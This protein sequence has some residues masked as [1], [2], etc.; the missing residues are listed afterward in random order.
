MK[1]HAVRLLSA[2]CLFLLI[3]GLVPGKQES[4][5]D[6]TSSDMRIDAAKRAQLVAA[7]GQLPLRF[8]A[9]RGQVSAPVKFLSRNG[10]HT[11]FLTA[12]EAVLELRN[13]DF[14]LRNEKHLESVAT[15]LFDES[16]TGNPK[17]AIVRMRL[18]GAN[19]QANVS[20]LDEL[21]GKS[22]Y[23]IGNDPRRW[24]TNVANF[25]RV[26]YDEV[27]PG[28]DLVWHGDQRQ[29][30][31]DFVLAPGANPQQ[32]RLSFSGAQKL[33]INE[34]GDLALQ[35][36]VG[37]VKLLKPA[38][39]Q[40]LS[41]QRQP[42][43]CEFIIN[44]K[45]QI[46][47]RLG[48]YDRNREL[49]IDPVLLYSTYLGGGGFDWCQG[50]AVDKDANAYVVGYTNSLNF[51]GSSPIQSSLNGAANDAF[52]VKLN[53]SGTE[54]MYKSWIGGDADDSAI[55][56]A[57]DKDGGA[58][59]GGN[60]SSNNFP[61]T[62][63]VL[64]PTKGV[65]RD[66]FLVRLNATG[67]A[68][69]Y[70]GYLGGNG[71]DQLNG[72][73]IDVAGNA[74][75]AGHTT[76]TNLPATGIQTSR[77]GSPIFKSTNR[78][79]NWSPSGNGLPVG[80]VGRITV[81]PSNSMTL[82]AATAIGVFKSTDGGV[83]WAA[84]GQANPDSTPSRA[85]AV[86][87]DPSNSSTVYVTTSL[88]GFYKSTDGGQ[89]YQGKNNGINFVTSLF[90]HELVI[91]P[92]MTSTLYL[93][94]SSGAYKSIN[95]GE[96]WT[97][98]NSGFTGQ[99]RGVRGM[100]IDPSNRMILYAATDRGV[101]KTTDGGANWVLAGNGLGQASSEIGM[102]AID[103]LS[104][105]TVYA[106][107]AGIYG[108]LFKTTDGGTTWR[109]SNIGLGSNGF[110]SVS[111]LAIDPST[112]ALVYAVTSSGLYKTIDGGLNWSE[113]NN[114]LAAIAT[115][116]AVDRTNSANVYVGV[117]VGTDGFAAKV[118]ATGS[119]F[120]WLTYLGGSLNDELRG[121]A[122]DK[123]GSAY[124][125]GIAVSNDFPTVSPFQ[126]AIGGA[127]DAIVAKVNPAGTALVYSTFFG[128]SDSDSA[129]AI[130]VNDAGQ[131][132]VTGST[133]SANFPTKNPLQPAYG[134][135]NVPDAF[136]A[137][138]NFA[139]SALEYST[140]LGGSVNDSGVAIAIDGLGNAYITGNTRSTNFPLMNP[141][142]SQLRFMDVYVAKL[143]PAGS[144]LVY[145]TLLGGDSDELVGSLAV[146]SRGNVYVVGVTASFNFPIVNPLQANMLISPDGFIAKLTDEADLAITKTVSR[147][148]VMVANNFSFVL[149]ATN[150]G[151][152]PATGVVV[153][154]QLPAGINFV[155]ATASQG[156]CS[157][158]AGMVTCNLGNLAVRASATIMLTVSAAAAGSITNT[159]SVKANEPDGISANN[160]ASAS[161]TVSNQPS[162]YGRVHLVNGA[163]LAGVTMTMTGALS[164]TQQTNVQGNFQFA[165]LL[166]SGN[167][168]V[169]PVSSAYSFE[170][171]VRDFNLVTSDQSGDFVA[172][173]CTYSLSATGQRFE[174][175]GGNDSFNLTAPPRCPWAITT[176]ASWIK[177]TSALS[178]AGNGSIS[179]SVEPTAVPRSGRISVGGQTFNVLQ[180]ISSCVQSKRYFYPLMPR[181]VTPGDLNGDGFS[182][183]LI[184]PFL[185]SGTSSSPIYPIGILFGEASGQLMPGAPIL[186]K[187]QPV[188]IAAGD[189]NGD[190]KMDVA[191]LPF[192]IQGEAEVFLNNG[193]SGFAAV[194]NVP[195]IP[196]NWTNFIGNL[197]TADLNKD[198]K[199]DLIG[200][201]GPV[202]TVAFSNSSGGNISFSASSVVNLGGESFLSLADLNADGASDLLTLNNASN[203]NLVVYLNNGAG[204][205]AQSV[206]T[207][208]ASRVISSD[209]AD[210]NGDGKVDLATLA[211]AASPVG[212]LMVGIQPGDG[213]GRFGAPVNSESFLLGS[214]VGGSR[215]AVSDVNGD[216]KPDVIAVG[217]TR[218]VVLQGNGAG[219]VNPAVEFAK[220][221]EAVSSVALANFEA[222]SKPEIAIADFD[223]R[224]VLVL[225][226][227]CS[228]AGLTVSGRVVDLPTT[229]GVSGVT[230]K[231]AGARMASTVTDSGGN[232][233]FTG[234]PAG[235]YT[236]TP[237]RAGSDITPTS[238]NFNLT[239]S[240]VID[241]DGS[242]KATAV[243][244]ASYNGQRIAQGSIVA[245]F[246]LQMTSQTQVAT[247]QP[248]PT[249]LGGMTVAFKNTDSAR[250]YNAPLFFVSPNQINLLV[251]LGLSDGEV[252]FRVFAPGS[253]I[254]PT[255]LGRVLVEQVAPG[256]F[257]AD[258]SGRGLAAA[259][260]LRVK[261]DGSQVYES[262]VRF[263]PAQN[264]FV[265]IPIDVGNPAEQVFLLAFGTGISGRLALSNFQARIGGETAEITFVGPQNDF[266]GLDQV[267]LRLPRV[268]AGRGAVDI[269]LTV[270]GKAAN[271]VQVNI[272]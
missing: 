88:N 2:V 209:F 6:S 242:R 226:N 56:I 169:T 64:Q 156:S 149:T 98:I 207:T 195:L 254:E 105:T 139:G 43:E 82:Y 108:G 222:D 170:P 219:G 110:L 107:T 127:A 9:N 17:S 103:P 81:D 214:F 186:A 164:A 197:R 59:I 155:S 47:F 15:E 239:T 29:L 136:V 236:L 35:T 148:P 159:A 192:S 19:A 203:D 68:L 227:R 266:V 121:I 194:V 112:P 111:S 74:Y 212:S 146:D 177:I 7:Y 135:F 91:D 72:L 33:Q 261:A 21:P 263:D 210:F 22:N 40:E 271:V 206:K 165:N 199:A 10:T 245:L 268:L 67:S 84:T 130:A 37:E 26:K 62:S 123:D 129:N 246:G 256:L 198:G 168:T 109:A 12:D 75:V 176:N 178:G 220:F 233:S 1:S 53:P 132:F 61:T 187:L 240:Q 216:G 44:N 89:S 48:A 269:T 128:G 140:W 120:G 223:K 39:W 180:G 232:Y 230:M 102:L 86:V 27:Y 163:P 171:A 234:L 252:T 174:A 116:V 193:A 231:L 251:P 85:S 247:R 190:G 154:D 272:K 134:G 57:V 208:V 28:I 196:T 250:E 221:D 70:S 50:V 201:A 100:A 166:P 161:V 153:T 264:K 188:E 152:S 41:G 38:A 248:L 115:A 184:G 205:F 137:K 150:N 185:S 51:P 229:G 244:A 125:A 157:N 104:P 238:R 93:A 175:T 202:V 211:L 92:V 66:A 96:N 143:N 138:F 172:T 215:I 241:F 25:A 23:F 145:S 147:N 235:N 78:A 142:Q 173:P 183:L 218:A 267:N 265:A 99:T 60:T 262:V 77:K 167:Y 46:G 224:N 122:V 225:S 131:A 141:L 160:Q 118:N 14:G 151:P 260:A 45:Q 4:K 34:A 270:D 63:G 243:S 18:A 54:I 217:P 182:D 253:S 189:F 94:T 162:I 49:V 3:A 181:F 30:E 24:R 158:N 144:A 257:S 249:S 69:T 200:A 258:A 106:A 52:V 119:A 76:S 101:F 228:L 11:L 83:Q 179:F 73:A 79:A 16:A 237:E 133:A 90:I 20:A 259:V 213:N 126:A 8:E 55:A 65:A 95:G 113:N 58:F 117:Y 36:E 191:S 80:Q 13:A 31:H 87:V 5:T 32:I 204:G 71:E 42:V 114:G 97:P 255:T 124:L